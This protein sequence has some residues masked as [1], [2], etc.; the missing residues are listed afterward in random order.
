MISNER[1]SPFGRWGYS[2]QKESF[3]GSQ[4]PSKPHVDEDTLKSGQLQIERKTFVFSLKENVRGRLLRI[5]EEV[6]G[7]RNSIIVPAPGLLEFKK[8]LEEMIKAAESLPTKDIVL[9]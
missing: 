4:M 3:H 5:T 9:D 7:K 8:V 2:N 6:G 1:P